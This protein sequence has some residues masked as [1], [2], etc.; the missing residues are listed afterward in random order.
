MSHE[1][2][3]A[4]LIIV[5]TCSDNFFTII[6]WGL[7]AG[8]AIGFTIVGLLGLISWSLTHFNN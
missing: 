4:T 6:A 8:Q 7:L 2:F 1:I 5:A 3:L